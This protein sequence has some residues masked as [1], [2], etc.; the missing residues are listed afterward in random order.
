MGSESVPPLR[1]EKKQRLKETRR[2]KGD[3]KLR[4][5]DEEEAI[6]KVDECQVGY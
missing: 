6:W 5:V 1:S 2:S 3:E 4:F